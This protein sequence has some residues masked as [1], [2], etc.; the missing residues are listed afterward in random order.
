MQLIGRQRA[1]VDPLNNQA[2]PVFQG[3]NRSTVLEA[4]S[5]WLNSSHMSAYN[6]AELIDIGTIFLHH[7]DRKT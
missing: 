4:P 3:H 2:S 5:T 1:A 7:F 6:C